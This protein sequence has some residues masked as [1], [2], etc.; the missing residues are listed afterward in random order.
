[1]IPKAEK[2]ALTLNEGR[3][4]FECVL[5]FQTFLE[6][7]ETQIETYSGA[8]Y[9]DRAS[10]RMKAILTLVRAETTLKRVDQQVLGRPSYAAHTEIADFIEGLSNEA[11]EFF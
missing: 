2:A 10:N 5:A 11:R 4:I 1:M 9:F 6:S 7:K 3:T 8:D